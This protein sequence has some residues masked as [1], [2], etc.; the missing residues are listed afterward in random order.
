MQR[1]LVS[2][3]SKQFRIGYRK[4]KTMLSSVLSFFSGREPRKVFNAL[5]SISF[6]V[7]EKEILGIIGKNGSGKT[8]LLRVLS[9]IYVLHSGTKKV[10]GRVI[11]LIARVY[12][13][14]FLFQ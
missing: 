2:D 10:N 7:N 9:D 4:R 6:S 12:V 8:T 13:L 1:I 14:A 11:P 3:I 5:D